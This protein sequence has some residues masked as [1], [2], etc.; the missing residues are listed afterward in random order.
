MNIWYQWRGSS[1]FPKRSFSDDQ[2]TTSVPLTCLGTEY[3]QTL[4][5][6]KASGTMACAGPWVMLMI[7][8]TC[9][10]VVSRFS[11]INITRE[12]AL[13]TFFHARCRRANRSSFDSFTCSSRLKAL[14]LLINL[15]LIHSACFIY[16]EEPESGVRIPVEFIIL[17]YVLIPLRKLWN[18]LF[19]PSYG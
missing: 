12:N 15:S 13:D 16:L 18:H 10:N 7:A 8:A 9:D 2:E 17:T 5:Y 19:S 11:L 1:S 14:C 6:H 3:G 4:H